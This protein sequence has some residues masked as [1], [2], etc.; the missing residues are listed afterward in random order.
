MKA[1]DE[2]FRAVKSNHSQFLAHA[3][4]TVW[5]PEE[6]PSTHSL[7]VTQHDFHF[8][9]CIFRNILSVTESLLIIYVLRNISKPRNGPFALQ[10]LTIVDAH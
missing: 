5:I 6:Y 2:L 3:E 4:K 8:S 1:G 10:E 9:R 7:C